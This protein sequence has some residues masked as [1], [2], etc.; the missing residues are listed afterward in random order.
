MAAT[1]VPQAESLAQLATDVRLVLC[2]VDR[3]Y[4]RVIGDVGLRDVHDTAS[5]PA[6]PRSTTST[7]GGATA[8]AER[9]SRDRF[10]SR[11]FAR[12]D[13]WT[14]G[15]RRMTV[16]AIERRSPEPGLPEREG[17]CRLLGR[18]GAELDA[19]RELYAR[20][21]G[22][23]IELAALIEGILEQFLASDRG[24]QRQRHGGHKAAPAPASRQ[25]PVQDAEA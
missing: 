6:P 11:R 17:E 13:R 8:R 19:H 25:S 12:A 5:P 3:A 7:T 23:E 14:K 4:A 2:Q 9:R 16:R 1:L 15:R 10:R 21:H 24:Y 20:T 18:L 22:Q